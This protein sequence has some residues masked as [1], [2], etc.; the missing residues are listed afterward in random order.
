MDTIRANIA[1][2]VVAIVLTAFPLAAI[3]LAF[4]RQDQHA[5]DSFRT[6]E[7]LRAYLESYALGNYWACL[8][9]VIFVGF[10]YAT[11]TAF[12]VSTSLYQMWIMP[13]RSKPPFENAWAP[14]T[15]S[16]ESLRA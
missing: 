16:A 7:D 12:M 6:Y 9:V 8:G 1:S 14:H 5:L 13:R 10:G 2:R 15:C 4:E 3:G 11:S